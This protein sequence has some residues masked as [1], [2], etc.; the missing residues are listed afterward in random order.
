MIFKFL[1]E[2]LCEIEVL[3]ALIYDEGGELGIVNI[4]L[5]SSLIPAPSMNSLHGQRHDLVST[6]LVEL[7]LGTT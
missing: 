6:S 1:S 3:D 2:C 4:L 7:A 5:N